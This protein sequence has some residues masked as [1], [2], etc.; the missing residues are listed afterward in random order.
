V[1]SDQDGKV[2]KRT[3]STAQTAEMVR[4]SIQVITIRGYLR[5]GVVGGVRLRALAVDARWE[6]RGHVV[7][8]V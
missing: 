2:F 3:M 7:G 4:D 1:I 6:R 8:Q 5:T